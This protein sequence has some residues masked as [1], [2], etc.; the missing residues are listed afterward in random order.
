MN[1]RKGGMEKR[2]LFPSLPIRSGNSSRME[3][4]DIEE[5]IWLHYPCAGS[6]KKR[7]YAFSEDI[8]SC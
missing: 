7:C 6:V 2:G 4:G 5:A 8:L 3:I 1:S